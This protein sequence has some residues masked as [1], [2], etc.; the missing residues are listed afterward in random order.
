MGVHLGD[1]TP[2]H[3]CIKYEYVLQNKFGPWVLEYYVPLNFRGISWFPHEEPSICWI[4]HLINFEGHSSS[5]LHIISFMKSNAKI[6]V[7][8]EDIVM[9]MFLH[10]FDGKVV[11]WYGSLGDK[12]ISSFIGFFRVFLK[13]WDPN[14][15]EVSCE[16]FIENL[17]VSLPKQVEDQ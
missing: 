16:I 14:N 1:S 3:Y 8:H 5:R 9:R 4:D 2:I 12:S 11:D 10:T 7:L 15:K 6:D 13:C 17:V